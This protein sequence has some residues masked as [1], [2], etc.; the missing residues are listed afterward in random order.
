[1]R[2][3]SGDQFSCGKHVLAPVHELSGLLSSQAFTVESIQNLVG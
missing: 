1:M 2:V 3:P